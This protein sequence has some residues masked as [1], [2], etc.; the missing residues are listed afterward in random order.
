MFIYWA[1]YTD[2]SGVC[3]VNSGSEGLCWLFGEG[4]MHLAAHCFEFRKYS[5][6]KDFLVFGIDFV[7]APHPKP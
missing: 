3:R 2:L 5:V 7:T 1:A 4:Y 6:Q